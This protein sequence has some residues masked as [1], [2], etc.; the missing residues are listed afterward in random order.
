[1]EVFDV[2]TTAVK[3][4]RVIFCCLKSFAL[5]TLHLDELPEVDLQIV[6]FSELEIW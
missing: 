6:F 1:M 3:S 5:Y 2:K 4:V